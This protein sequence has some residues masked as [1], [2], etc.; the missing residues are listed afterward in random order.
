[1]EAIEVRAAA[2]RDAD[3]ATRVS[4]QKRLFQAGP[5]LPLGAARPAWAVLRDRTT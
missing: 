1:M 2:D 5:Q 3:P 4:G